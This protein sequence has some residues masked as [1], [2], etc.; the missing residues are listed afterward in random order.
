MGS[1]KPRAW[2][3]GITSAINGV[4]NVPAIPP[5][6]P[7][8]TLIKKVTAAS[9]K[10]NAVELFVILG[11]SKRI[12]NSK[13]FQSLLGWDAVVGPA[14]DSIVFVKHRFQINHLAAG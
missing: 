5:N 8:D 3:T 14:H 10:K 1:S 11:R 12:Q 7:F 4:D 9:I 2:L 13:R 6:P